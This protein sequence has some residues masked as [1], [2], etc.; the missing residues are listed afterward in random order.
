MD[1]WASLSWDKS[2]DNGQII[3]FKPMINKIINHILVVSVFLTAGTVYGTDVGFVQ[4][5]SGANYK[6]YTENLDG[7][8]SIEI[9]N[10]DGD[11]E[12]IYKI[13]MGVNYGNQFKIGGSNEFLETDNVSTANRYD[14]SH[15]GHGYWRDFTWN[16]LSWSSDDYNVN[17]DDE[18]DETTYWNNDNYGTNVTYKIT[19]TPGGNGIY[20]FAVPV[21]D[22]IRY[23]GGAGT[24][25]TI[26]YVIFGTGGGLNI[27][28]AT[29]SARWFQYKIEDND[30]L[31]YYGFYDTSDESFDEGDALNIDNTHNGTT[32]HPL[33]HPSDGVIYVAGHNTFT[34]TWQI[35]NGTTTTADYS[36]DGSGTVNITEQ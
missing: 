34:Y 27:S 29:D 3:I 17:N 16:G 32:I 22:D 12:D 2:L 5:S 6:V 9:S 30:L 14:G 23:E 31:P 1:G 10:F 4:P 13:Y 24:Y 20:T 26:E 19:I 33:A 28:T 18:F 35:T 25:E 21:Y 7:A 15:G 8:V 36:G 11:S